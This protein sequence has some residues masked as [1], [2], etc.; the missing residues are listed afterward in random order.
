MIIRR[1]AIVAALLRNRLLVLPR[2]GRSAGTV[3]ANDLPR[4]RR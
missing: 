3:R 1:L 2:A 4:A